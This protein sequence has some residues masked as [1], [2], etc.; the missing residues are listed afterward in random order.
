MSNRVRTGRVRCAI[1]PLDDRSSKSGSNAA[2]STVLGVVPRSPR[3][4]TLEPYRLT[5]TERIFVGLVA[6]NLYSRG[7]LEA[8]LALREIRSSRPKDR[9]LAGRL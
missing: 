6:E 2:R 1:P 4:T 5:R 8:D 3:V 9:P 7:S